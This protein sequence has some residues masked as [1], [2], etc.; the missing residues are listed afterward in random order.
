VETDTK[1]YKSTLRFS[2][3]TAALLL[4]PLITM[5][6][7]K[8]VIWSLSDFVVAGTLFFGTGFTYLLITRK[9][10]TDIAGNTVYRIGIGAALFLMLLLIW[11]NGAVGIIGS[12]N[13]EI[14]LIYFGVIGIGII[15]ALIAR[16]QPKGMA[17]S[18]FA[19]AAVQSIITVIYL[20]TNMAEIPANSVIEIIGVN[21]FFI[22]L[23]VSSAFIFLYAA[24]KA[25]IEPN[26]V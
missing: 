1:F 13:N 12:E 24:K 7:T 26:T 21:S 8:E 14:N 18:L 23:F 6:F 15:G 5:Q 19:L 2:L 16:F 4:I 9:Q 17:L 10:A 3:I 25:D 11:V 20:L 22:G